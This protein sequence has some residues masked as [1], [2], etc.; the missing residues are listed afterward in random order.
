MVLERK[1]Y[2]SPTSAGTSRHQACE[3]LGAERNCRG[4]L[5]RV[6]AM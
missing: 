2:S 3:D 1:G 4:F 5:S 6:V